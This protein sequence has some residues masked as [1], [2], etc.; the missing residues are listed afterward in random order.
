MKPAQQQQ[1]RESCACGSKINMWNMS[2][3]AVGVCVWVCVY[4][5]V[6]LTDCRCQHIK[7]KCM[8]VGG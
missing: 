1:Q 8:R 2:A 4:V 7:S 3:Q 6:A 5:C